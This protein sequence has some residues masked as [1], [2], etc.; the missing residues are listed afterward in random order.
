MEVHRLSDEHVTVA[1]YLYTTSLATSLKWLAE[2]YIV[3]GLDKLNLLSPLGP[4]FAIRMLLRV[5]E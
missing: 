4:E 5:V 1:Q 3:Q 2:V